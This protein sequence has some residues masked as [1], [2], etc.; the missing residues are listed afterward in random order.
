MPSNRGDGIDSMNN[1][2]PLTEEK[3]DLF[4]HND[5]KHVLTRISRLESSIA[6]IKGQL[7]ILLP[8]AIAILGAVG[9]LMIK[10]IK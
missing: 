2:Q 10:L 8:V 9:T 7:W 6:F 5:F 1:K 4:I 3:F